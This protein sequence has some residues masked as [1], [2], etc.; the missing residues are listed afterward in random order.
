VNAPFAPDPEAV[1]APL[2]PDTGAVNAPLTPGPGVAAAPLTVDPDAVVDT[3]CGPGDEGVLLVVD[4][5]KVTFRTRAGVVKAVDGVSWSVDCGETLGIV[6]ESGSGKSVSVMAMLGLVPQPPGKIE[7]GRAIFRGIDLLALPESQLVR[8]RGN[9][10]SMVFQDPMTA[11]N[12]VMRIGKQVA[13]SLVIHRKASRR[14]AKARAVELLRQVGIP[15]PERRARDYPHEFSGGMRQRAMIAMALACEPDVIIADEPTTALDVTI[16]AQ[17]LELLR[18][19][20]KRTG[21]AIVVITHDLGVVAEV[22]D[23]VMCMYAGRAAEYAPAKS[24]YSAPRH[25]Y[26]WGLM[27]SIPR[28][29]EARTGDLTVIRGQPPS[30]IDVPSGCPFH[31]RCDY[32]RPIC[33]EKIPPLVQV[34]HEHVAACHFAAQDDFREK[35][36]TR[37][38]ARAAG[39]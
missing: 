25:P 17:I 1:N 4:R 18:D 32:A 7:G 23:R 13:E 11:L 38:S 16:Q 27:E 6:G 20:Q 12:P 29:D 15:N 24:F 37:A 2:P 22:A 8:Y 31:P 9:R 10:I 33:A 21:S 36:R 3:K 28:H 26:T 30:L 35:G 39:A 19:I 5:L 14:D 34:G